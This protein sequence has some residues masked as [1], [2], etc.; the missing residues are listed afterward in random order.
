MRCDYVVFS[1]EGV[2]KCECCGETLA[3]G[4]P[5]G[6]GSFESI[7]KSF[8]KNHKNCKEQTA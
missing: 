6:I 5:I 8:I 4:F 7:A 1:T 3:V 2:M